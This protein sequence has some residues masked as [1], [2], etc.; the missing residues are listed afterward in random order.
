MDSFTKYVEMSG[1]SLIKGTLC[2]L[3][4]NMGYRCNLSC[5]HCH[6]GAGPNRKETMSLQVIEDIL[7]FVAIAGVKEV[8]ITGGAPET[9]QH[10]AIFIERLGRIRSVERIL[11]RTNLAIL[12]EAEYKY[13]PEFFARHGVDLVASMPC[14]LEENVEFQRGQGVYQKN[15]R[16]LQQLNLLGYGTGTSGLNLSLAYNPGGNFLP[17]PQSELEAAYKEHLLRAFGV[18][19]DSLF[20]ITNMPIGRFRDHLAK[21]GLLDGYLKLLADSYN[22]LNLAKVMCRELVSVDWQGLLYDCDFNQIL[23]KPVSIGEMYIGRVDPQALSGGPIAVGN[24]C[25][26]CVAGAGSSCRGSLIDKVG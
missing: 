19:F 3:Q 24:H 23:K 6:V 12:D 14:Y 15:I 17:G 13:L 16:I 11:L 2:C 1:K 8:D 26:A 5:S 18:V 22:P 7:R 25:F 10:L 4:V 21:Q 20:T 9:N